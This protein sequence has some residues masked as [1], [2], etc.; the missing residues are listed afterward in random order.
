[1]DDVERQRLPTLGE[2]IETCTKNHGCRVLETVVKG[3][4]G[5]ATSRYLCRSNGGRFVA[6]LPEIGNEERLTADVL[7]SLCNRIHL[8][9]HLFG[10]FVG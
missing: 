4:R 7:S 8:P 2:F 10:L 5:I 3:P 6:V 9:A 1:M